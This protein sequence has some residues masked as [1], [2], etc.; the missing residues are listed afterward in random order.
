MSGTPY[1]QTRN[2]GRWDEEFIF[3]QDIEI[4]NTVRSYFRR[5]NECPHG[6]NDA[7]F[8]LELG[9]FKSRDVLIK[10]GS[11]EVIAGLRSSMNIKISSVY[12]WMGMIFSPPDGWSILQ[13][14]E[15]RVLSREDTALINSGEYLVIGNCE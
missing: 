12:R 11:G 9:M 8:P 6:D 7:I 14:G 15:D 3:S 4:D 2:S 5:H 13:V 10:N 1:P